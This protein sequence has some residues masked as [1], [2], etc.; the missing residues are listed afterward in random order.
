MVVDPFLKWAGGKRWLVTRFP[1]FFP[2]DFEKYYEPFLGSAA[3]FF[4]LKPARGGIISDVNADLINAYRQMRSQPTE[5]LERLRKHQRKHNDEYYY[6]V[7]DAEPASELGRAARLIYLN[8]TCWNGLY[9]VN[10]NGQFNVPRGTKNT[11][12]YEDEDFSAAAT[13]LRRI[14]I[15]SWDFA[16]TIQSAGAG[17]FVFVDPPYTVKHNFNG[18]A[19]YNEKIFTWQDQIRLAQ[20]IRDAAERGAKILVTNA[21]HASVRALYAGIGITRP[22]PRLSVISGKNKGRGETTE[23][24]VTINYSVQDVAQ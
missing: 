8:R 13:A 20:V 1:H 18:F 11:V 17:D 12:V 16:R 2:T 19:K 24:V 23:I 10:L 21:N 9:R 14:S 15:R 6:E 5:L 4:W 22:L 3:V 7:R